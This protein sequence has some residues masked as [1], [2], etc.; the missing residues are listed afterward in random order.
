MHNAI[1]PRM[2]H[3]EVTGNGRNA[4]A[5]IIESP[6][7]NNLICC[8]CSFCVAF[9]SGN[10]FGLGARSVLIA[11]CQAFRMSPG[12][13]LVTADLKARFRVDMKAAS[14]AFGLTAFCHHVSRI[15]RSLAQKQ[16]IR[17]NTWGVIAAVTHIETIRN[18]SKVD[19]PRDAM[20]PGSVKTSIAARSCSPLP[21]PAVITLDD[22]TPESLFNG[23][24]IRCNTA[25]AAAIG[26]L[27]ACKRS[28]VDQNRFGA[29]AARHFDLAAWFGCRS[30]KGTV[31]PPTPVMHGTHA[32]TTAHVATL[33]AAANRANSTPSHITLK[34]KPPRRVSAR[35]RGLAIVPARG[36]RLSKPAADTAD[37]HII[38]RFV[39][40]GAIPAT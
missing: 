38:P 19:Q 35:P 2:G 4:H 32:L 8:D 20:C 23:L 18:R 12:R 27:I 37:K 26:S 25:F 36:T 5:F 15:M 31:F 33:S 39:P 3:S 30:V 40:S 24:T 13:V 22:V 34:A 14:V 10:T 9:T 6:H 21:F 17:P 16:V 11:T 29:N 1:R 7:L 28:R